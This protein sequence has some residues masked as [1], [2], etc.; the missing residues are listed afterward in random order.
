MLDCSRIQYEVIRIGNDSFVSAETATPEFD[1][2]GNLIE[3]DFDAGNSNDVILIRTVYRYEFL[4]PFIGSLMTGDP[5]RNW[6]NHMTTIVL[7]AEPYVF[8]E[9]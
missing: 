5:S 4:T 2:D 3:Q 1:E 8:G 6:M 7:K 9:D